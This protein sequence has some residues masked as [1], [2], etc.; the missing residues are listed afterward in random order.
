MIFRMITSIALAAVAFAQGRV[1]GRYIVELSTE[2]VAEHVTRAAPRGGMRSPAALTHRALVQAEQLQVRSRLEQ[3]Q[4]R[5]LDSIDTVANAL[6]VELPDAAAATL[7]A[8]PGVKRVLPVR[9]MHMVLDR[10]VVLHK[11]V[12]AWN[13]IGAD[14]AGAGVK[15]AIIDSGIDSANPGFQ[16]SSLT[17]P[18]S[19]PRV[20]STSDLAYTNTKIIVARS[21]V[22]MLPRRDPDRSARDHVGHGTALAMIAAGATSA[23]PLATITGVAPKAWLGNYKVF[24]TPGYNDTTS[25]DAIL[26]AIDDAV[27]DGMDVISLSLGDDL[28]PR[29]SD[30]LDVQAVERASGAGVIVVVAAGNSGPDLNT[31]SSPATAPSAIAVGGTTNDR[32]F[33]ASVEVPGLPPL[34]AVPASG[35]APSTS[36]TAPLS[37]VSTLD[38]NGLSCSPLPANSLRNHIALILRGSCYF[39][40]KLNNAQQAGALAALV[41]AAQDS[42][43]P[44]VMSVGTASLPAEMISYYGG[45]AIQQGLAT[46]PALTGTLRFTLSAVPVAA[47]RLVDFSAAGP[48][49]DAGIKPDLVAVGANVYTATETLDPSGEM[50]DPSGFILVDGT[51]FSTPLVA[52][53]AA[54]LKSARPGLSVDQYRS[55]LINAAAPAQSHTGQTPGVQQA[56]A[57]LLDA[58]AALRSTATAYPASLS[59]GAGSPD[60]QINRTLTITNVGGAAE[61]FAIAAA[62]SRP[63]APLPAFAS[64][65]V[66]LAAGA[67]A[68]VPVAWNANGLAPGAYEGFITVTGTSSGAQLKVPYW[69]AVTSGTPATITVLDSIGSARRGSSQ[70]DAVLFRITEG[71][72]LVLADVLPEASVISGGGVVRRIVSH[73]TAVPG[74]FGLNVQIGTVPA[75]NVFRIQAGT[76][77]LDVTI[78]GQ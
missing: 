65:T 2:P 17:M 30:D 54:L 45:I 41:Y 50:Y 73:D 32:T 58:S 44:F 6:F 12:D 21:Y 72:G 31:M 61:I 48:N 26:K 7:A 56:G 14:R 35:P 9:V 23:G 77:F 55:L 1:P 3:Q 27:S 53:A 60:P 51:S 8:I 34:V 42:P 25:D 28:A 24:G 70:A 40:T 43:D 47:N 71:S 18:D 37:D 52:G 16:D 74:V 29:L 57:G 15:I 78:T 75:L 76:V 10:A 59:L 11:V 36:V 5:V 22:S 69:Y 67:S 19:F 63:D 68:D 49:V 20:N 38:G 62:S 39:E 33:A 64:S 46:E 13:Q 66:E 4:V